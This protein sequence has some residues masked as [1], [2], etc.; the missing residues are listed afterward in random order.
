MAETILANP[1]LSARVRD[2]VNRTSLAAAARTLDL[3][4][5]TVARLAGGLKVTQGTEL[6]ATARLSEL[7]RGAA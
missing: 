2:L 7:D 1:A 3:A 6:L 4:E 5:A